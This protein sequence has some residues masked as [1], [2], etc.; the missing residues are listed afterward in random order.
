[1]FHAV[2]VILLYLG[3]DCQ[4]HGGAINKL[5]EY[6]IKKGLMDESF[7]KKVHR[8]YRLREKSNYY[9]MVKI[10]DDDVEKVMKDSKEFVQEVKRILVAFQ[11]K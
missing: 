5:G 7:S 11:S 3:T 2:R 1:M 6:V 10:E 4:S 8:A 9:S